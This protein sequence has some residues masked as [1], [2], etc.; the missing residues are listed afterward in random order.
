MEDTEVKKWEE[1][2]NAVYSAHNKEIRLKAEMELQVFSTIEGV[3]KLQNLFSKSRNEYT[4]FY[5]STQMIKIFT[6]NWNAFS[7]KQKM[8]QRNFLRVSIT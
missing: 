4:L 1:I 3:S 5:A 2:C 8:D 7:K 6:E